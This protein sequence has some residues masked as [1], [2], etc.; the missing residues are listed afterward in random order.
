MIVTVHIIIFLGYGV[1]RKEQIDI[2]VQK[3][4]ETLHYIHDILFKPPLLPKVGFPLPP[5]PKDTSPLKE[6]SKSGSLS[7][8]LLKYNMKIST[9][10]DNKLRR[11]SKLIGAGRDWKMYKYKGYNYFYIWDRAGSLTIKDNIKNIN[12]T[13]YIFF[14][15]ILLNIVFISFYIFLIRKLK[16]LSTLK[17]NIT[18]FS[19]GDLDIDTSCDGK[20]E[21]CEVSN[22]FNNAI[23][24]IKYLMNSRDLFLRN[25]L[26]E[27]KTPIAKGFLITDVMREGKYKEVL[28]GTFSRLDYLIKEFAKLEE[29]TAKNRKLKKEE[30]RLVDVIDHSL[31]ILLCDTSC[32]DLEAVENI[33]VKV[34]FELFSLAI[35]NLLDNA[36][37]YGK[38]KPKIILKNNTMYIINTG[39]KLSKKVEQYNKPFEKKYEN[40]K[41]GLG[42]GLYLVNNILNAHSFKLEYKFENNKN[43]FFIRFKSTQNSKKDI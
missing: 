41:S 37:K 5:P 42:L 6:L 18:K 19:K 43:I 32:I 20:D 22:E 36:I 14:L 27:L 17:K 13:Q 21:I 8:E 3:Y 16:P 29:F 23:I 31:D 24:Q 26:H 12:K 30:F 33:L 34:D 4:K 2:T 39:K 10:P 28:K 1:A 25:I 38:E 35:K 7:Q 15:A 40:S 11:V 9:I